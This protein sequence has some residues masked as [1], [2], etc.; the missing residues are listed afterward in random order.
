MRVNPQAQECQLRPQRT[1]KR[2]GVQFE[3]LPENFIRKNLSA[4]SPSQLHAI[5]PQPRP[6]Y[7][8]PHSCPRPCPVETWNRKVA[9]RFLLRAFSPYPSLPRFMLQPRPKQ[10]QP[11]P[12]SRPC[13]AEVWNRKAA[14]RFLVRAFS[15]HLSL[16]SPAPS[17][18]RPV[19][20]TPSPT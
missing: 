10:A 14:A 4:P 8:Q 11:H 20:G 13:S 15:S 18:S 9:L 17:L 16:P 2:V 7:A 3:A 19:P 5:V 6:R 12:C 1:R